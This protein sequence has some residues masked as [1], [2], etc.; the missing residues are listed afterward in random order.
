MSDETPV[1]AE[2]PNYV[3]DHIPRRRGMPRNGKWPF[4]KP[5]VKTNKPHGWA[6][7]GTWKPLFVEAL[8]RCGIISKA[9]DMANI[10][11]TTVRNHRLSD[12]EF[13]NQ[14]KDAMERYADAIEAEVAFRAI[15]GI[16]KF[17]WDKKNNKRVSL[18][19]APNDIL[20]MFLMK[21]WRPEF[22]DNYRPDDQDNVKAMT[23]VIVNFLKDGY[24]P[25]S[26]DQSEMPT[27][28][29]YMVQHPAALPAP[30]ETREEK[31]ERLLRELAE[32]ESGE[33]TG[34][35]DANP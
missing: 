28:E 25:A 29:Q 24:K 2:E 21:K 1:P 7:Q 15:E 22:R 19:K 20:L 17:V 16:E 34:E 9:A 11:Q 5:R 26:D 3:P 8:S 4:K 6:N 30:P 10:A 27:L 18:G 32:L 13:D 14:C 35:I 31:R 33:A 12:P 23:Q